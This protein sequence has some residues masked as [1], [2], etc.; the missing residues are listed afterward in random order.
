MAHFTRAPGVARGIMP[1]KHSAADIS[2]GSVVHPRNQKL[3]RQAVACLIRHD[4][5]P[6]EQLAELLSLWLQRPGKS[7]I[8]FTSRHPFALPKGAHH[9]LAAFPLGPLSWAETRKLFRRLGGLE[10]LDLAEQRRAYEEVGG[11]PR[12]L[13]YLDA[14]LRGGRARPDVIPF[15]TIAT[16]SSGLPSSAI[17]FWKELCG[18]EYEPSSDRC[19]GNL[20]CRSS[21]AFCPESMSTCSS[22]YRH[23]SRSATLCAG[24][25]V[26]PRTECRWSSQSFAN[27][28]GDATS[29]REATSAR[30]AATSRMKRYF[31]ISGIMN[32]PA[33]AGSYSVRGFVP[34][35]VRL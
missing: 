12:A 1:R 3:R 11:H 26:V 29:G 28:T 24:S 10:R 13:E 17:R 9:R 6:P 5:A 18:N 22:R 34:C 32:L 16:T 27:V 25:K 4:G 31:S 23:I 7:R 35:S 20:A 14:I 8:L 30:P 15:F 19:P 2:E 21:Q 33:P